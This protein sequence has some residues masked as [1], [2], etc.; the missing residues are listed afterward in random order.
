MLA[1]TSLKHLRFGALTYV[2]PESEAVLAMSTIGELLGVPYKDS[3]AGSNPREFQGMKSTTN[4]KILK[5]FI[6]NYR[7]TF[8]ALHSGFVLSVTK[9]QVPRD[10]ESKELFFE[11]A[12]LTNGLQTQTIARILTLIKAYQLECGRQEIHRKINRTESGEQ[13]WREFLDKTVSPEV[14]GQLASVSLD[15]I[16]SVLN[17]LHAEGNAEYLATVNEMT[18]EDILSTRVS[19]KVVLLDDLLPPGGE[20]D[21][22]DQ[23]IEQ[24]GGM[25]AEANN[26]TQKVKADD[27][28][29]T[30]HQRWLEENLFALVPSPFV[31]EYRRFAEKGIDSSHEVIHVLNLLRAILPT[32]L[33][34]PVGTDDVA[35]FV[36]SY[37]SSREP[38]YNWFD[39]IIEVHKDP[40]H[41]HNP[42]IKHTVLILRNL[43]PHLIDVMYQAQEYWE[44]QR[45]EL[46]FKFVNELQPLAKTH[47]GQEIHLDPE[48]TKVKPDADQIVKSK[49]SFAFAN[50][51]PMFVFGTRS[52]IQV[53][54]NFKVTYS[55]SPKTGKA[56]MK[57]I[58][59]E[60]IRER[61]TK[62]TGSTSDLFRNPTRYRAAGL[63]FKEFSEYDDVSYHDYTE[64]YRVK[65]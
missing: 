37:A 48:M 47:L 12:C 60:L 43:M 19:V 1:E 5:S 20:E 25:I 54:D 2:T 50:L 39:R 52:A 13:R 21:E 53:D 7:S 65:L 49:L 42:T 11:D 9:G 27:L 36:A 30:K 8:W 23:K 40:D 45:K 41:G 28:F 57:R 6:S 29:G 55:I 44:A 16:N 18:L 3:A 58:Y 51:F 22:R 32:T 10:G 14:V 31:V 38:V 35:S 33:I 63:A 61:L 26:E 62:I 46:S 15:H 59:T 17:W 34:V 56:V 24:L 64:D 4:Q